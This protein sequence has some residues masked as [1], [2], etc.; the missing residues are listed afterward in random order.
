[1]EVDRVWLECTTPRR[2]LIDPSTGGQPDNMN[3]QL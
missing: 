3:N 1:M 2:D